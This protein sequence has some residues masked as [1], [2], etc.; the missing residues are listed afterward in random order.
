MRGSGTGNTHPPRKLLMWFSLYSAGNC[1]DFPES[2][3]R[4]AVPAPSKSVDNCLLSL[5]L[6]FWNQ[7]FTC[8][9]V[10]CKELARQARS[11]LLRYLFMSKV[12]SNWKICRFE[13]MVRVFFFASALGFLLHFCGSGLSSLSVPSVGGHVSV[14]SKMSSLSSGNAWQDFP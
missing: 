3:K 5:F 6:R 2:E 8:V 9:S 10:S 1:T 13:K 11:A 14:T 12:D 4:S 7:I